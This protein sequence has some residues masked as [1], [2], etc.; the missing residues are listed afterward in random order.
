[1]IR[2][3]HNDPKRH[4]S[5][6]QFDPLRYID[7]EQTSIDAANN[8]DPTKRDHFVF[9]AGR[10]RCGGIHIADRSMFLAISRL[11]WAFD[12]N[13]ALDA[14]TKEEITPDME[15]LM[16]GNMVLPN[17]FPAHIVPRSAQKAQA[18]RD[19]WNEV[20]QLLDEQSQ[21]KTVPDGLIWKDE[22]LTEIS[23]LAA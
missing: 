19:E 15:D 3:I 1:M 7:D 23:G 2:A 14:D 5:P 13:K 18:V 11:L 9:G 12:F 10:R 16:E 17:P 22:Q 20:A 21:W 4:P 6:R 8:A